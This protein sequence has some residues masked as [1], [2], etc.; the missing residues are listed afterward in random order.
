ML[1]WVHQ[2]IAA[3][4]EFLEALFA[5]KQDGR[6]VGSVRTFGS[7][8]VEEEWIAEM[9]DGAAGGICPPLKVR[10]PLHHVKEEFYVANVRPEC[11]KLYDLKRVASS[12]T[13][14]QTF[15]NFTG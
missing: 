12:P 10:V 1:A 8:G 5:L 6:M 3:E 9:M 2:A 11:S 7:G 14:S 4:R 15:Y 13:K